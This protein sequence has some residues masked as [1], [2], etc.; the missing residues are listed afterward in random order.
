MKNVFNLLKDE[1]TLQGY[2]TEGHE[3][4]KNQR[5]LVGK[6]AKQQY[7]FRYVPFLRPLSPRKEQPDEGDDF[8]TFR[9]VLSEVLL[10]SPKV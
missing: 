8:S 10:P 9:Q 3:K 4:E 5:R 6:K 1:E 7:L 2:A